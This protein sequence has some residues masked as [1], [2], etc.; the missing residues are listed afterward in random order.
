MKSHETTYEELWKRILSKADK[1]ALQHI[2]KYFY[3]K[4]YQYA[5]KLTVNQAMAEDAVHDTFLYLW[6]HRKQIGEI[7][8]VQFYLI[9]SVRNA[10]LKLIKK[11]NRLTH[12]DDVTTHIDLMILPSELEFKNVNDDVKKRIKEALNSLSARQREIIYLKFY[13][14]LDYEEIGKILNINYQSVV[15]HVYKGIQKLRKAET[16]QF[17]RHLE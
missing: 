10:C 13:N 1:I 17:F 7:Q 4:L 11:K 8:S 3:P 12:I 14:N 2:Y 9:R 16:L 15:N 6:Q 5:L